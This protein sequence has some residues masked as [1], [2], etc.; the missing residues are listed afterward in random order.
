MAGHECKH[1]AYRADIGGCV[2]GYTYISR[3]PSITGQTKQQLFA[4]AGQAQGQ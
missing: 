4:Y 2:S 3:V 1:N